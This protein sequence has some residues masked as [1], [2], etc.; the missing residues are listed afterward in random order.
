MDTLTNTAGTDSFVFPDTINFN[1][2]INGNG[3]DTLDYAAYLAAN[4]ITANVTGTK[5]GSVL[6]N[7]ITANFTGI[8]VINGGTG[9]DSFTIGASGTIGTL[10]GATGSD[11]LSS[12]NGSTWNISG[13]NAG[14]IAS[15]VSSFTGMDTLTNTGS[16]D[17]FV[18]PDNINFNGTI[19]GNGSDTLDY[20]AYL[21]AHAIA[22]NVTG[23]KS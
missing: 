11:T 12:A 9:A 16:T 23:T 3:S 19:N 21:A 18:F 4:A 1:G 6:A 10:A 13:S 8:N 5:S 14:S 17:S 20:A 15:V 2:T 7:A 22:A